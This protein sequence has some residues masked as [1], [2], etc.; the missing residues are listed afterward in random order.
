MAG[1]HPSIK[2]SVCHQIEEKK[3]KVQQTLIKAREECIAAVNRHFDELEQNIESEVSS[4]GKKNSLHSSYRLETLNTLLMKEVNNLLM[5]S[6]DL[7][8]PKFLETIQQVEQ[9]VFPNSS[10]FHLR[11][12]KELR[13]NEVFTA[14][15]IFRDDLLPD[16]SFTLKKMVNLEFQIPRVQ[17]EDLRRDDHRRGN[18]A[19]K[20]TNSLI[21]SPSAN[22]FYDFSKVRNV[23]AVLSP[24]KSSIPILMPTPPIQQILNNSAFK[25]QNEVGKV[26]R[27]SSG[28]KIIRESKRENVANEDR[29]MS[30][31][32]VSHDK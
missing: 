7:S 28:L 12:S 16:L 27:L 32:C 9:E 4:E 17:L 20:G 5:Y 19:K 21:V 31:S 22:Q 15:T 8:S 26:S 25:S 23:S 29:S 11:V 2:T 13:E 24:A 30:S 3:K 14:T 10:E 1:T 6:K 18:S